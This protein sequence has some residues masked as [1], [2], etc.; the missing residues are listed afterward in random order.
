MASSIHFKVNPDKCWNLS[1][2]PQSL[3]LLPFKHFYPSDPVSWLGVPIT[4]SAIPLS[5]AKTSEEALSLIDKCTRLSSQSYLILLKYC[6]LPRFTFLLRHSTIDPSLLHAFDLSVRSIT[7]KKFSLPL[8]VDPEVLFLPT[9][10]RGLGIFSTEILAPLAYCAC[11]TAAVFYSR[12]II[13]DS[14]WA[15]L[16]NTFPL[17]T[18]LS[19]IH[20]S[21]DINIDTNARNFYVDNRLLLPVKLQ[22]FLYCQSTSKI[23]LNFR[24]KLPPLNLSCLTSSSFSIFSINRLHKSHILPDEIFNF[25]LHLIFALPPDNYTRN[26]LRLDLCPFCH[27]SLSPFHSLLCKHNNGCFTINHNQICAYLSKLLSSVGGIFHRREIRLQSN[28][29]PIQ[30]DII[31]SSPFLPST[32]PT[33]LDISVINPFSSSYLNR[34]AQG[35]LTQLRETSKF[36]KY[37]PLMSLNPDA[38]FL[39]LCVSSLGEPGPILINFLAAITKL[40]RVNHNPQSLPFILNSITAILFRNLYQRFS[41]WSSQLSAHLEASRQTFLTQALQYRLPFNNILPSASH[42]LPQNSSQ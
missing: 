11:T 27:S 1:S 38:I 23:A 34:S 22:H 7:L 20:Q 28:P 31:L 40:S 26:I 14:L 9:S 24:S 10:Q 41:L 37:R 2:S 21:L 17:V 25:A 29:H 35:T 39:P 15:L 18:H 30:P 12:N 4:P 16:L 33:F 13:S 6:I 3:S 36:N 5:F 32:Q 19:S 42:S 8:S